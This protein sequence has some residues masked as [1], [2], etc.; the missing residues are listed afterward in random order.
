MLNIQSN[1]GWIEHPTLSSKIWWTLDET[2]H[3]C[4][5][6]KIRVI[7]LIFCILFFQTGCNIHSNE[8]AANIILDESKNIIQNLVL[9]VQNLADT[10]FYR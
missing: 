7:Q 2:E 5:S 6:S 4:K 3:A 1:F 8:N 9:S 10:V